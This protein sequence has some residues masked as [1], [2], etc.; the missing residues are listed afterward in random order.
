MTKIHEQTELEAS[1]FQIIVNLSAM[2]VRQ[3]RDGL[4]LNDD[5]VVAQ[6]VRLKLLL[7]LFGL[8]YQPQLVV[9][10]KRYSLQPQFDFEALLVDRLGKPAAHFTVD[11]KTG[12]HNRVA[13]FLM[14][15]F[16]YALSCVSCSSWSCRRE[17]SKKE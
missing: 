11:L 12:S 4:D 15:D 17:R 14:Y 5:Q 3:C 1:C 10:M 8:A 7:E 13:L 9:G 16:H 2:L 6:E